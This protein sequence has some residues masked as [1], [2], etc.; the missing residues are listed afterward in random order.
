MRRKSEAIRTAQ[1]SGEAKEKVKYR[2]LNS[3]VVHKMFDQ[4]KTQITVEEKKKFP[5]IDVKQDIDPGETSDDYEVQS[6]TVGVCG[7]NMEEANE[8]ANQYFTEKILTNFTSTSHLD[9]ADR[10]SR[11]NV[12]QFI[13]RRKTDVAKLTNLSVEEM[14]KIERKPLDPE[15]VNRIF[16]REKEKEIQRIEASMEWWDT[17]MKEDFFS[18]AIWYPPLTD[19]PSGIEWEHKNINPLRTGEAE[20]TEE[21]IE[22]TA[23]Y[24]II[25]SQ[26]GQCLYLFNHFL[27]K[28]PCF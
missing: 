5:M 10:C 22:S 26:K 3:E 21:K 23:D 27:K 2:P 19:P 8:I 18:Q 6:L 25:A 12:Q 9:R 20:N 15:V 4:L 16:K 1:L 17:Q 11:Y 24:E 13:I 7:A 28:T 14:A